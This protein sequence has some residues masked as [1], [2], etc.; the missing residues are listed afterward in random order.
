MS[1]ISQTNIFVN[2][3]TISTSVSIPKFSDK[4]A[5]SLLVAQKLYSAGLKKR[6]DRIM[7]CNRVL[8]F[9]QCADCGHIDVVSASYCRDRLC[10][11]CSWR[12]SI[13]RYARMRRILEVISTTEYEFS[14][15]TLTVKNCKS[16]DLSTTIA[17][18]SA[19]WADVRRQRWLKDR[20]VGWARSLEVTYN[21]QTREVHPHFHVICV[22][23]RASEGGCEALIKEWLLRCSRHGLVC[24][25][26]AQDSQ[27]I[28]SAGGE[29]TSLIGA[30]CETF[31]YCVKSKD[32]L[33]GVPLSIVYDI[34]TGLN[35]K[36]LIILGGIIKETAKKLSLEDIDKPDDDT[37]D[38]TSICT[39][40][41][42]THL[43]ELIAVWSL[44]SNT[45]VALCDA[46]ETVTD[47]LLR[48]YQEE[49]NH[50]S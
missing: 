9:S 36:K 19:A 7:S 22:W 21:K 32:L 2:T 45:Y 37:S 27:S 34:A 33:E 10:P 50:E 26:S 28:T 46:S 1:I 43:D 39:T 17:A 48:L 5:E 35:N 30:I 20:L 13:Q 31:K 29:G 11:L 41:G 15:V 38:R 40:C 44:R 25:A 16:K 8:K 24:T 4:K 6:G 23:S 12:L 14:L 49:K 42:G 3:G 47:E 18:M